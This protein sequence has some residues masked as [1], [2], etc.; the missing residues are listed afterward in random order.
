MSVVA[1]SISSLIRGWTWV[2][3][4]VVRLYRLLIIEFNSTDL[5]MT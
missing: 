3:H 5:Y 1:A 2:K 4:A